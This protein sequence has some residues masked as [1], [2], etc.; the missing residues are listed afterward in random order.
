MKTITDQIQELEEENGRLKDYQKLAD[1]V[2]K[3]ELGMS[4]KEAKRVISEKKKTSVFEGKIKDFF[5]LKSDHDTNA[6]LACFLT[7]SMRNHYEK[8]RK[9]APVSRMNSYDMERGANA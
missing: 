2:V 1:K 3:M 7:D 6:F 9:N 8:M 4:A 5:D